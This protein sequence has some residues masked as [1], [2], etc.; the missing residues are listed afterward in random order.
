MEHAPMTPKRVSLGWPAAGDSE[1]KAAA[2]PVLGVLFLLLLQLLAPGPARAQDCQLVEG[3]RLKVVDSENDLRDRVVWRAVERRGG[4]LIDDPT[5]GTTV[6]ELFDATGLVLRAQTDPT[7]A[8]GWYSNRRGTRWVYRE[9]KDPAGGNGLARIASRTTSFYVRGKG[10]ALDEVRA[11]LVLPATV[12]VT[13]SAGRCLESVFV[14]CKRN[15]D[16]RV[17]CRESLLPP[18]P[19]PTP[20]AT[21]TATAT[22]THTYTPHPRLRPST[23]R[24]SPPRLPTPTR[25]PPPVPPT[26][27]PS[28]TPAST[29]SALPA[30]PGAEGFGATT[31]GGRGGVILKVTN[32]ADS[33][34]GSLRAAME[35]E[36][37]RIVVFEVGG[38]ID[39]KKDIRVA[40]PYLTVAGQTAPGD[41][42]I[43]RNAGIRITS[44][45]DVIIRGLTIRPGDNPEGQRPGVRRAITIWGS[46]EA[47]SYN[48]VVDHN[49]LSW[50]TDEVVGVGFARDVTFQYN[51]VSE[52]LHNSL[53]QEG[54][55]GYAFALYAQ[56]PMDRISV[57]HNLIAHGYNRNPQYANGVDGEAVNNLIYNWGNNGLTVRAD[58]LLNIVGNHFIAG[59]DTPAESRGV[60]IGCP[61]GDCG[62]TRVYVRDNLGPFRPT[63]SG[64]EWLV[65]DGDEQYRSDV[66]VGTPS[67]VTVDPPE[68]VYAKL[69]GATGAGNFT[70]A[71]GRDAVDRRILAELEARGGG[72]RDCVDAD[73]IYYPQG[74]VQGATSTTVTVEHHPGDTQQGPNP[75]N[76][77]TYDGNSIEITSG[78]ARGQVRDVA[79]FDPETNVVTVD[80]PWDVIP[81]VGA[82]YRFIIH[83]DNNAGGWPTYTTTYDAPADSDGD[84]MPDDWETAHGLNPD[85]YD[86]NGKDLSPEGYDNVEVYINSLIPPPS[87]TSTPIPDPTTPTATPTPEA[88]SEL[89]FLT[90]SINVQDFAYP[91][92]SIAVLHEIVD[93]HEAHD[94]PVD[95]FLTATMA[96]LFADRAPELLERL[97]S[98]PVV[99]VSY[100]VRPPKPYYPGYDWAGLGEMSPEDQYETIRNYETHGLD[101]V[102]GQPTADPGGYQWLAQQ[103]GYSPYI[104]GVLAGGEVGRSARAV[105][106]DLGA[107]LAVVHGR[108]VNLGETLDGLLLK[109]E[110]YDLRLFQH[111]GQ[112]AAD[113][114][115]DALAQAR[116]AGGAHP[117]YFVGVKMHDN[118]FFA[119]RAA[120]LTVYIDGGRRPPWNPDLK[121]A[122]L[123][124]EAREQMWSLYES[125]VAYADSIRD[126][127]APVNAPMILALQEE[128]PPEHTE[129]LLYISGTMHIENRRRTWPDPDALIAF[130]QRATAT[131]MRWSVGADIDWLEQEPRAGEI[132][133]ATE[134]LGVE[135]DV[136]THDLADRAA[137]A[138]RIAEL[139]GHPTNVASGLL[140]W[141][142]DVLREPLAA[143]DGY[144]WQAGVLWGI[145]GL[146]G[147]IGH[148]GGNDDTSIGLWRPA[149]AAEYTTH[150]PDGALIAVGSGTRDN[151]AQIE[152]LAEAI[153][154]GEDYPPVLSVSIMAQPATLRTPASGEGID[155]IEAWARRLSDLP[156]VR[157]ATI[158]ET[159][160]AWEAAG[161][162]PSRM[163]V[164][165]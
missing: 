55:H 23:P 90:F 155:A 152:A 81:E 48:I 125:T 135:W 64:D 113:I 153:A 12:R 145:S 143:S 126:R 85:V 52:P 67:G 80:R 83:C 40:S 112:D 128:A 82:D 139:G 68:A 96:D 53:H 89:D 20:S 70:L 109:P 132:I 33:G 120:W 151:L 116:S 160:A 138:S 65:V 63:D 49:S 50:S 115:E 34:P 76:E 134:A 147:D 41:G 104:I 3:R 154:A 11:P 93:L 118:D 124:D 32:L 39:L 110:H 75:Q 149:S 7:N 42:V 30:F 127:V 119:E 161:A 31:V 61:D 4:I 130:L 6:I 133:R 13:T 77:H 164:W 131:G 84:G 14:G 108:A 69:T 146:T 88:S 21:P 123:S 72:I 66:P 158:A 140:V 17:V 99:A 141:E 29:P 37:P 24:A 142:I 71:R 95:V 57:H 98:S 43:L 148:Q 8:E 106:G 16:E 78:A 129:T 79:R 56:D 136:H 103:L 91:E 73:P 121:S 38:V 51:I 114:V 137:A 5:Q 19:T 87:G 107:S 156:F 165:P 46:P 59:P 62:T 117:P 144:V 150:D 94:V 25:R 28:P 27:T 10:P 2:L 15:D 9:R 45:H 74:Q 58:V 159:A 97:V 18:T 36:G 162:P 92:E 35:A 100:H 44:T 54:A 60:I 157:W 26:H 101:P 105:F 22:S 47:P 86:A 122:L 163:E 111:V 1:E 102:T